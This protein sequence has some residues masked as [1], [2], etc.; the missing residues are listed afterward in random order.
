MLAP[1]AGDDLTAYP[2]S[3]RGSI[4]PGMKTPGASSRSERP[5]V[6]KRYGWSTLLVDVFWIA[7]LTFLFEGI[8][9]LFRFGLEMESTRDTGFLRRLTFG[10]RIHH[11]YLGVVIVGGAFLLP[12]DWRM[13]KWCLRVGVAL[14]ASDL[15]H[16]FLVLWPITGD[17]HFDL[18]YPD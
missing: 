2:V 13:R 18:A 16:H 5:I 10:L 9:C 12:N 17:P 3:T 1:H 8:T 11:G 4:T 7:C 15:T 14:A 6:V